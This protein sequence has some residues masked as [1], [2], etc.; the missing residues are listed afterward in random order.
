MSTLSIEKKLARVC[1]SEDLLV[2]RTMGANRP[3]ASAEQPVPE[4][5]SAH[6]SNVMVRS[7]RAVARA[8]LAAASLLLSLNVAAVD[9]GAAESLA[10]HSGCNKCHALEKKKDGPALRDV[11]AKYRGDEHAQEKLI[12]HITSGEM[13]KFDDGHKEEHKK[14]KTQD[15]DQTKNLVDWILSLEGGTKY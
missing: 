9:V 7:P 13:V 6:R 1:G 14:V 3:L 15:P 4:A 2:R 5:K 11:A 8:A 12:K 10:K